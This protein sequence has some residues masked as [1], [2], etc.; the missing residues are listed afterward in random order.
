MVVMIYHNSS[1]G[2][3]CLKLLFL[4]MLGLAL[5]SP[6]I[7]QPLER[8]E[9]RVVCASDGGRVFCDA[10][11]RGGVRLTRQF[12]DSGACIQGESWGYNDRAIWV[13]RGCAG[14]FTLLRAPQAS[15]TI[16]PG[17]N[18]TVRTNQRIDADRRDYRVYTA[19][20]DQDVFGAD[21]QVAIPRGAPVELTVRE[22]RDGDLI[23][24]L[25]SVIA[26]GQIYALDTESQRIESERRPGLG[27]NRSTAEH[28]GGGAILG[29]IIGGIAGGGKGAA[30]GAG[31]GAAAGAGTQ[32]ITRG[33]S[34]HV[35]AESLLTFRLERPL[36]VG[37][38]DYGVDRSGFHY[39]EPRP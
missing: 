8:D 1:K 2:L 24:D 28:V 38:P 26:N 15:S 7:A 5:V 27:E 30:I 10:D 29:A 19:S 33:R 14:E 9:R 21:G 34:V 31:A 20:V 35:P 16:Q 25:E 6:L 4:A 11:T 17:T 37:V 32:M 39:H 36:T 3:S 13:D 18:I 22:A 12:Q 23:L